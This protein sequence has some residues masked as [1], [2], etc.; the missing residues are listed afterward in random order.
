MGSP[1][2]TFLNG[3]RITGD[4]ELRPSDRLQVGP[5]ELGIRWNTRRL[6]SSSTA[7]SVA[8]SNTLDEEEAAALLLADDEDDRPRG[9]PNADTIRQVAAETATDFVLERT[10]PERSFDI[11]TSAGA[12]LRKYLCTPP[13]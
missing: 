8:T 10:A 2:G 1:Q 6:V 11:A 7:P 13:T 3:C 9:S 12:A 4:R 5:L